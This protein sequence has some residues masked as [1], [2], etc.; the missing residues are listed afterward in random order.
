MMGMESGRSLSKF[1]WVP[2]PSI[3]IMDVPVQDQDSLTVMEYHMH[4]MCVRWLVMRNSESAMLQILT[5]Q[6]VL[7]VLATTYCCHM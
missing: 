6:K 5:V 2:S 4:T 7:L 1:S 3:P